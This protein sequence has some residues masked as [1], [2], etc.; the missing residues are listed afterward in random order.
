MWLPQHACTNSLDQQRG[1]VHLKTTYSAKCPYSLFQFDA[2]V[3]RLHKVCLCKT[4]SIYMQS[5]WTIKHC[6][7]SR[8]LSQLPLWWKEMVFQEADKY[9]WAVCSLLLAADRC[10]GKV[11]S[12]CLLVLLPCKFNQCSL[13]KAL[14]YICFGKLADIITGDARYTYAVGQRWASKCSTKVHKL[15]W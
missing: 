5:V 4:Y 3:L 14:F 6:R 1:P 10:T 12:H 9:V 2:S 8:A 15:G 7:K 11:T 13:Q